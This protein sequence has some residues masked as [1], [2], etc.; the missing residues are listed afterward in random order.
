VVGVGGEWE[1]WWPHA[2]YPSTGEAEADGSLSLR[3]AWFT[4]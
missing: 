4:E 2:F 1:W 3:P